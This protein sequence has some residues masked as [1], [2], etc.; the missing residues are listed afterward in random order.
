MRILIVDD[1][2]NI[3]EACVKSLARVGYEVE[4]AANAEDAL[5]MLDAGAF[6][7]ALLDIRMPG[8][9]GVE[10]LE[11]VKAR[12]PDVA[13]VMMTGYASVES[14]VECIKKGAAE[15]VAKPFKPDEVRRVVQQAL[16]GRTAAPAS[17]AVVEALQGPVTR[18]VIFGT[19]RAMRQVHRLIGKVSQQK[20]NVLVTGESGTGKELVARLIHERSSRAGAP[21]VVVNCAAIP[22]ALLESELFGHRKGAFTGAEYDREGSFQSAD[23]GTLFMDEVGEMAPA[24][25]AK[26]LRAIESGEI[27]QVGSDE[28][29]CTDVR[30]IAATNRDLEAPVATGEFRQDL[31]YRLNVVNIDLPPL[32]KR[33][34][35]IPV[36]TRHFVES[37]ARDMGKHGIGVSPD[38]LEALSCYSWPGNVRELENAIERAVMMADSDTITPL[39]L[40]HEVVEGLEGQSTDMH[41]SVAVNWDAVPSQGRMPTLEEVEL[42]YMRETLR[43]CQGNRTRAAKALGI[44]PVT[45]WRKLG[46][47][48]GGKD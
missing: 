10:L 30:V 20:S 40:P 37:F 25:Q 29:I 26:I 31:F 34:A 43:R 17:T 4:A 14:A 38:A 45:I 22:P 3:R 16:A 36:L 35:D 33:K 15:Y 9:S 5:A 8:M 44:T 13:V 27:K 19:S 47:T 21:F 1:E 23:T 7:L 48:K 12:D 6:D 2:E 32:R 11:A 39:D 24:M 18:P 46:R 28:S 41:P 42:A